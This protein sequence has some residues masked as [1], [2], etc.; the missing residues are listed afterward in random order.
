MRILLV[1]ANREKS[2]YPVAP[3]GCAYVAAAL[4]EDGF[5][6]ELLDLCFSA[7]VSTAIKE[8]VV[9]FNPNCIGLSIRNV[10]NLSYPKSTSYLPYLKDVARHL[11]A[12]GLPVIVGGSGYSLFPEKMLRSLG[13]VY[14]VVGEGEGAMREFVKRLSSGADT[15]DVPN[16][17]YLKD[18]VFARNPVKTSPAFGSPARR[19]LDN[20]RYFRDGGMANV[21][22]KRGCPFNCIYCTYPYL[23]GNRIRCREACAVV[24]ELTGLCAAGLDYV[25]FVDDIFNHPAH[26]AADICRGIIE[27]GLKIKWTCFATPKGMTLELLNLMKEAG[28][29]G[30]E[31]GTDA[32]SA[33]M[34]RNMGKGFTKDD[35]RT[36]S[37]LCAEAGIEAAHYLILGG[38]GET[39]ETLQEAFD[40]M[41]EL[42][43]RAVI[44]MIGVRIYPNTGLELQAVRDG[45]IS[46]DTDLL[47]SHFYVSSLIGEEK[48]FK[49]IDN[50]ARARSNWVV[51]AL[52][53]RGSED[54]MALLRKAGHRG[55]LWDT[56]RKSTGA[57]KVRAR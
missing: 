5:E 41:D 40:F 57:V 26:Q 37:L 18:G 28:C 33:K 4:I 29:K 16:L 2:P 44:V 22:T 56:L 34:L 45:V 3:I 51:T 52:G 32:G 27:R 31:F 54:A 14:G 47:A 6:V 12:L 36:V 1:S 21:Q 25:F 10:D 23:D 8:A 17:A 11:S 15:L 55:P 9:R 19:L 53:I 35:I 30:V 38:P 42:D 48:L 7:D 46:K 43:P 20:E 49:M 24:D 39:E 13:L 50:H